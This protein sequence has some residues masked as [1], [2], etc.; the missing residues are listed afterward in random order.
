MKISVLN[1]FMEV[2]QVNSQRVLLVVDALYVGGTETHVLGLAKELIK[3]KVFVSIAARK[4]GSLVSSFEGLNC[5]IHHIEFPRTL[6]L[7]ETLENEL[8]NK[9]EGIIENED[10]SLVH[11]HQV[12]SGYLAGKAAKNK[13]IATVLTIHGTYYPDHEIRTLL[14][15]SDSVI[16]VSPPLCEYIKAFG[17][18][19]PYLVPNGI[20]VEEY[21]G[22]TSIEE[23]RND[24][25]I[26]TDALVVLYASRITWAKANVCSVFLRACKDL[27]FNVFPNLHVV[28][29]GDGDRFMDIK[30]LAEMIENMY[31]DSFIHLVG[32]QKNM[33]AYYSIADCI[34]GTGRVALEAMASEKPVIAVGNHG[35]FGMVNKENIDEAWN[36]YFGDHSSKAPCSRHNLRDEL[37]KLLIN[38]ELLKLNGIVSREI[39][40]EKFNLEKIIMDVITIYSETMKKGEEN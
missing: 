37:K 8:V 35:F 9:I 13:G 19:S 27:K 29:V 24:L 34:V 38:K 7:E 40:E 11:F 14:G 2:I 22:D 33:H 16:C 23:L 5:P 12:P 6:N 10:I 17:I 31:K 18:E 4:S 30:K 39:I 20:S 36:H 3:N 26:P 25:K 32:E 28:V 1:N 15:L 21:Q